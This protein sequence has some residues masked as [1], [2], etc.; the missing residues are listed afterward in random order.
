[1]RRRLC[2]GMELGELAAPALLGRVGFLTRL[3]AG[4]EVGGDL[5]VALVDRRFDPGN[6]PAADHEEDH[7]QRDQQPEPLRLIDDGKLG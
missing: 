4:R 5:R 2:I 3:L 1:V 6:H 7:A